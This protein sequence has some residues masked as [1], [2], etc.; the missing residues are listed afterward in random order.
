MAVV[1]TSV[2]LAAPD[3]HAAS[4]PRRKLSL[5]LILVCHGGIIAPGRPGVLQTKWLTELREE[6]S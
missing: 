5:S 6:A 3:R 4:M 1:L 2:S